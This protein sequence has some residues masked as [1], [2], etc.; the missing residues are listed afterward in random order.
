MAVLKDF[1]KAIVFNLV[2]PRDTDG[3]RFHKHLL[4]KGFKAI[5]KLRKTKFAKV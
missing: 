3:N 5:K 1:A 2:V 4:A